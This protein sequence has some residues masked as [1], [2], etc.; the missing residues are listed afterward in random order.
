MSNTEPIIKNIIGHRDYGPG[1]YYLEIEFE[2]SKT[3]WMLIDNVKLRKPDLVKKYVK[4]NP[5]VK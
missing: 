3:G 2:N 1:G 5:E 4:N